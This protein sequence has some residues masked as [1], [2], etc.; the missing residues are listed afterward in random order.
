MYWLRYN[1]IKY[2]CVNKYIVLSTLSHQLTDMHL[3]EIDTQSRHLS[4][5]LMDS[6]VIVF[7]IVLLTGE[8]I[9]SLLHGL[10]H[11]IIWDII[12]FFFLANL[13]K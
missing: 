5:E 12:N 10:F 7:I 13:T 4:T 2:T 11:S 3:H 1:D 6:I 9:N 8:N